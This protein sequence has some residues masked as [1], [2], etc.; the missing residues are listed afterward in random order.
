MCIVHDKIQYIDLAITHMM[1]I[2]EKDFKIA[3]INI[4]KN[5]KRDICVINEIKNLSRETE[6]K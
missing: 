6:T 3:I 5:I 4:F 2:G 1:E